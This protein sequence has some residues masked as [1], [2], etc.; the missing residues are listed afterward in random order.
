MYVKGGRNAEGGSG[1]FTPA[2][3][4]L[5][6]NLIGGIAGDIGRMEGGSLSAAFKISRIYREKLYGVEGYRNIYDL[7][8]DKFS[9]ARGTC[10]NLINICS[11]FGIPEENTLK[12]EYKDFKFSQLVV[13]LSMPEGLIEKVKPDMT[14][15][16]LKQIVRSWKESQ[17]RLDGDGS[18]GS[19]SPDPPPPDDEET[20]AYDE[21]MDGYLREKDGRYS[22]PVAQVDDI[23]HIEDKIK[24]TI[25]N[26]TEDF[27][28]NFPNK[29][30]RY[31]I[32][33]TW[34]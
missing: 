25:Q 19:P 28:K 27:K 4:S 23:L 30:F 14:V 7:A 11:R 26:L 32:S 31:S 29:K 16:C 22:I 8:K 3:E 21:G 33:I 17:T 12:P 1:A 34:R 2:Q 6:K 10:N 13:M 24:D 9:L 5:Y 15:V 18:G 20:P